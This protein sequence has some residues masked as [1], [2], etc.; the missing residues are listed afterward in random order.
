MS[1]GIYY[2]WN[3]L[4]ILGLQWWHLKEIENSPRR[5]VK[6]G[7]CNPPSQG[8][9][10]ILQ[11]VLG[12]NCHIGSFVNLGIVLIHAPS[13]LTCPLCS[14]HTSAFASCQFNSPNRSYNLEFSK[15]KM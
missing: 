13:G 10:S 7:L 14:V 11:V 5:T 3:V 12:H 15:M 2:N 4:K 6:Q 1:E 9:P 8:C